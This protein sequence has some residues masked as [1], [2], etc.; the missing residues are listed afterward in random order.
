[1]EPAVLHDD[2]DAFAAGPEHRHIFERVAVQHQQIRHRAFANAAEL[3]G[4][5]NNSALTAQAERRTSMAGRTFA[6]SV[7]SVL[8]RT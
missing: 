1:M 2:G 6:R 8:W 5:P 7:N 3:S 4:C